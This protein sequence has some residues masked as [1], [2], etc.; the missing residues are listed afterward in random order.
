MAFQLCLHE[1]PAASES[2]SSPSVSRID[3]LFAIE[4]DVNGLAPEERL[5][6]RAER[7]RPLVDDLSTWLHHKRVGLSAKSDTAKAIDDCAGG[8][9]R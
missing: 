1:P 4:H 6:A 8:M 7:T 5:A 3:A 2:A 9:C